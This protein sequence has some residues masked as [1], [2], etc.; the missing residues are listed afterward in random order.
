MGGRGARDQAN[1]AWGVFLCATPSGAETI[2][3]KYFG[4]VEPGSSHLALMPSER[5]PYVTALEMDCVADEAV[6]C[7]PVSGTC[8]KNPRYSALLCRASLR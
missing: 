2:A 7:E 6:G 4:N 5:L 3:V 8:G 1:S